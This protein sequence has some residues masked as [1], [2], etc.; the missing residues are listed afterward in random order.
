MLNIKVVGP[1]CPNCERLVALCKEV[2]KEN[3]VE[4]QLEKI[5]DISKFAELGIFMTPGLLINNQVFSAGK[6]PTKSALTQ[7]IINSQR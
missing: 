6:M 2:I 7:W 1:G 4:A 5:S 3:N